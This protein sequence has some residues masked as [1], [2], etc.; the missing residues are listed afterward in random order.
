MNLNPI[1]KTSF[2]SFTILLSGCQLIDED[3][4][5]TTGKMPVYSA[6]YKVNASVEDSSIKSAIFNGLAKKSEHRS[7]YISEVSSNNSSNPGVTKVYDVK[8]WTTIDNSLTGLELIYEDG[9]RSVDSRELHNYYNIIGYSKKAYLDID[10]SKEND[11]KIVT[12]HNQP[13]YS[14]YQYDSIFKLLD[15]REP[16]PILEQ[17]FF[18]GVESRIKNIKF[19]FPTEKK[20]S[21]T[22]TL[23]NDDV[24]AFANIQRN[25]STTFLST[26]NKNHSEKSGEFEILENQ[27]IKFKLYP[28]KKQSKVKYDFTYKY[29]YNEQGGS[30]FDKNYKNKVVK[31]LE[32]E[33]NK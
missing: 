28:Y 20:Y 1:L 12:I 30:D 7:I 22:I 9:E 14:S 4:S 5:L 8:G 26:N 17:D 3:N 15:T 19:R 18:L 23:K 11:L 29:F 21:G 27:K 31:I 32:K 16:K 2:L 24:T 33:F 13:S 10:I 25:F 6:S